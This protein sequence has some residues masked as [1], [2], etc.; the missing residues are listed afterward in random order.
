MGGNY[1]HKRDV[2]EVVFFWSHL[3]TGNK[4]PFTSVLTC[5]WFGT[6]GLK[7]PVDLLCLC[8][9]EIDL[10]EHDWYFELCWPCILV[11]FL[12]ITYLTHL[13][14]H[15][16]TIL[17]NNLLDALIQCIYLFH[18]C[19]CFEQPSA[20]H[21]ENQLFQY[22]IWYISLCVGD[23]YRHTRQSSTQSDKY[24]MLYWYNWFSW[25]WALG[26]SKHVEK[27]NK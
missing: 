7:H 2:T 14:V 18:F 12:L 20:H 13:F 11:Q 5:S 25:W 23:W 27:W 8:T 21:Q 10:T 17:V 24:Q 9:V 22:I 15:L 16:G 1:Q 19:T 4:D 26:C 6:V 3:T